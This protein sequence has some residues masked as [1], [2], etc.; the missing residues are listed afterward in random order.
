MIK[1]TLNRIRAHSPCQ[2]GWEKLL[3]HLGKTKA[4]DEPPTH[5]QP[6]PTPPQPENI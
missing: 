6:L 4:D 3:N 1:T 5:W 2:E